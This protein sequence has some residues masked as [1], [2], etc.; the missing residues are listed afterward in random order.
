MNNRDI[1]L[2]LLLHLKGAQYVETIQIFETRTIVE[3]GY[4]YWL[5]TEHSKA[6]LTLTRAGEKWVKEAIRVIQENFDC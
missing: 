6:A 4:A 2:L 3:M 5:P 1:E